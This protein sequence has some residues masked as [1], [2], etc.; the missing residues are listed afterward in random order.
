MATMR[1]RFYGRHIAMIGAAAAAIPGYFSMPAMP[2]RMPAARC[3]FLCRTRRRRFRF[4]FSRF[5][6]YRWGRLS[7]LPQLAH[8]Q[9]L[10]RMLGRR[11]CFR[12]ISESIACPRGK[13]R[14]DDIIFKDARFS[15]SALRSCF[16]RIVSALAARRFSTLRRRCLASSTQ[17]DH[18]G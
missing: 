13:T 9:A 2:P 3:S 10:A 17:A 7:R 11:R 16:R 4:L 12:L 8:A 1:L 14:G 6:S 15:A 18:A 5:R